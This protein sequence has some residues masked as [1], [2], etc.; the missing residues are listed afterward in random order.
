[1]E[2]RSS[3]C[4]WLVFVW[5]SGGTGAAVGGVTFANLLG[6]AIRAE[7]SL[8]SRARVDP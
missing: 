3:K 1:M 2:R 8:A 6:V 5:G 4:S 7:V